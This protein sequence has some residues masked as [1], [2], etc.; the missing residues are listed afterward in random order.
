M[1]GATLSLFVGDIGETIPV[2]G[3]GIYAGFNTPT[4]VA[5]DSNGN[6]YVADAS[7][8]QIRKITPDGTVSTFA[9][10]GG[11]GSQ[12]GK[13]AAASFNYPV[14]LTV[15]SSGNVYVCDASNSMIRKITPDGTVSTLAGSIKLGYADGT[16]SAAEFDYPTGIAVDSSGNLYVTDTDNYR[17]RKITPSGAVSTLSGNSLGQGAVDGTGNTASFGILGGITID[18]VGNLYVTDWNPSR[19]IEGGSVIRKITANGTV[20]TI[21]G[22]YQQFGHLNGIGLAAQF[23]DA[24]GITIDSENNLYVSDNGNQLIRKI[25]PTNVVTTYAGSGATGSTDGNASAAS[26]STLGSVAIDPSGNV[27]VADI[28]NNVIRKITPSGTVSTF[29]GQ[30]VQPVFESDYASNFARPN[31]LAFDPSGNLLVYDSLRYVLYRVSPNG[32]INALAGFDGILGDENGTGIASSFRTSTVWPTVLVGIAVDSLGN[33]YLADGGNNLI[34]KITPAGV[35]TTFAGNGY[36]GHV[37]GSA[38]SAEFTM[39][40]AI[41]I[42]AQNNLYVIDNNNLIRKITPDGTVSTLAGSGTNANVNGVGSAASFEG[43]SGITVDSVGNIYATEIYGDVRKITP[44][45]VVTTLA[46]SPGAFNNVDGTGLAAQFEYPEGIVADPSG[47]LFVAD[48][49]SDTIRMI[50]PAGVVTTIAGAPN[51]KYF[52]PGVLPGSVAAPIGLAFRAGTLYISTLQAVV[53][54][55][56]LP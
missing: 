1:S 36:S 47:N 41:A 12:N 55:S 4:S 39:P 8:N 43:L 54:I 18:T 15:D 13:G 51:H 3:N 19:I 17:I 33:T 26:F 32:G 27:F 35:V 46:G 56:N 22:T 23:S 53:T 31:G 38:T 28:G 9:G 40:N 49:D 20:T 7:N 34:R 45:G 21:A 48:F 5:T 6:V 11:S 25:T 14:G 24:V 30:A 2:N 10:S 29:A 37:D 50:T 42:D 52:V 16:G 44:S